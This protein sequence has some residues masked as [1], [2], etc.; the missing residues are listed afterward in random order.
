MERY[1]ITQQSPT[2]HKIVSELNAAVLS[3]TFDD[4]TGEQLA[5]LYSCKNSADFLVAHGKC[6][7]INGTFVKTVLITF[8]Q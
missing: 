4:K 7:P 1:T 2:S 8:E 3:L 5:D 6:G